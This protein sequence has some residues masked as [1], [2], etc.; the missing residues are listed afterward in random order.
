MAVAATLLTQQTTRTR[1]RNFAK[2]YHP[3]GR[4][5]NII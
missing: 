4:C 1:K 3:H 5:V 2:L